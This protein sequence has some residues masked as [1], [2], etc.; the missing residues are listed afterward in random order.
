V[1][2]FAFGAS[3]QG[4][5]HA[6][7]GR[8]SQDGW[9]VRQGPGRV[10]AVVT[11]G[12][13]SQPRSEVGALLGAQHLAGWLLGQPLS[14]GLPGRAADALCGFIDRVASELEP[15]AL[16]AQFLF[17]F[18]ALVHAGPRMLV[19]GI[20]DGAL[21]VDGALRRLDPGPDNA[22]DYAAY[23]LGGATQ[24]E[25]RV[26]FEGEARWGAVM[27]DGL[28]ELAPAQLA[29]LLEGAAGWKNPLT[30]QR[31]LTVLAEARPFADDATLVVA[32][33]A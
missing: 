14:E 26:H 21:V 33:S 16:E 31:R 8:N 7:L 1:T 25:P 17:T 13:G 22:P 10:V 6:R 24:P 9:A 30:L 15:G 12:C 19:F 3:R 11:D 27:T 18:L 2:P 20:G 5:A 28:D 4:R 23:R 32:G 29:A